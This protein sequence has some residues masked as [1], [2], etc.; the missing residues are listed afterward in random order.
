[1]N[2]TSVGYAFALG[3][4]ALINP[5]G[6]PL[7]PAYLA[8]FVGDPAPRPVARIAAGLRAG[9]GVTC[10]FVVVFAAAGLAAGALHAA[11][12]AAAPWLMIG[13]GVGIVVV[14]VLAMLGRM[15]GLHADV[16]FRRGRGF[17]AMGGFGAAYAVGSL[18]CSLPVFVAAVG[19]AMAG[20]SPLSAGVAVLAYGL[21]MGLLATALALVASFAGATA[22]RGLR[23]VGAVLPRIAGGVCVVAGGYLV[24]YWTAQLGGPDVLGPA[25]SAVDAVQ[26]ALAAAFQNAGGVAGMVLAAVLAAAV[27]GAA[28]AATARRRVDTRPAGGARPPRHQKRGAR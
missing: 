20:A 18:S 11:V 15:P 26:A 23:R 3:M 10:G 19:G 14:G 6:F 2:D 1:M 27:I 13:V 24:A 16:G 8:L 28:V 22:M 21:G 9:V 5:C 7:L 4:V 12:L 25:R 17:A